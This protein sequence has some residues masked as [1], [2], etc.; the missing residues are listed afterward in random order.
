[1]TKFLTRVEAQ[2]ALGGISRS[3][4]IRWVQSGRIKPPVRLGPR[5]LRFRADSIEKFVQSQ[6]EVADEK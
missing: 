5:T 4:L 3:T 6:S 1:M 2:E